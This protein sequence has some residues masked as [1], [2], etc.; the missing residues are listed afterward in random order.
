M[1][2]V[3]PRENNPYGVLCPECDGAWSE[4]VDT[5]HHQGYIRRRRQCTICRARFTTHERVVQMGK[6]ARPLK[7]ATLRRALEGALAQ[8]DK[9]QRQP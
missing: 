2:N 4:T 3:V 5:R 6:G 9:A 7:M 8:I 1:S